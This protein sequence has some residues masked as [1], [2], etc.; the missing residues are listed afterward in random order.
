[1][2]DWRRAQ[3]PQRLPVMAKAFF[4]TEYLCEVFEFYALLLA[5]SPRFSPLTICE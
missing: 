5:A 3:S 4:G 2:G 1:M